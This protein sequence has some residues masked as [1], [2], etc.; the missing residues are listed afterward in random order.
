MEHGAANDV[1]CVKITKIRI[2]VQTS[3]GDDKSTITT[4]KNIYLFDSILQHNL[5]CTVQWW[6]VNDENDVNEIITLV[7][8]S[9]GRGRHFA[10]YNDVKK[11]PVRARRD[12]WMTSATTTIT[13]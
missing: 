7:V 6:E 2:R 13:L 8:L 10:V 11:V 9:G 4:T 1:Q 3:R 5:W 12:L